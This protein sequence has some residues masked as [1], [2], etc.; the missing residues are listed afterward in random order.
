MELRQKFKNIKDVYSRPASCVLTIVASLFMGY[1]L[2]SFTFYELI[3]G[4]M[5]KQYA[6]IQVAAQIILSILF[7]VNITLLW[8]KLSFAK[9]L[10]AKEYGSTATGSVLGIL[11]SGCPVCGIT[12]ASYLGIASVFTF[13]PFFGLELKF[14]GILLLLYSINYLS[15]TLYTCELPRRNV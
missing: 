9:Q 1:I 6:D 8:H 10:S 12:V 5:G 2:F 4:N 11:V 13:F 15:K 7:G 14:I 3:V